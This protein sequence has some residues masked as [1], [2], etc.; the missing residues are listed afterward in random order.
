MPWDPCSAWT[1]TPLF[2][3]CVKFQGFV[4]PLSFEGGK[5]ANVPPPAGPYQQVVNPQ[6]GPKGDVHFTGLMG[7][8]HFFQFCSQNFHVGQLQR[9]GFPDDIAC[10]QQGF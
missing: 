8:P 10:C 4:A 6:M 9:S 3:M 7:L 1:K 2:S 5:N